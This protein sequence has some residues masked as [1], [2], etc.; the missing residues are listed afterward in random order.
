MKKRLIILVDFSLYSENLIRYACDWSLQ[1][2]AE[3]L[4]VHQTIVV[5]PGLINSEDKQKI[6]QWSNEEALQKLKTLAQTLIPPAVPVSF[7]VSESHLQLTL[8]KLLAEPYENLIFV[9]LKGTGLLKKVFLGSVA[10]DVIDHSNNI[11]VAIPK[12]IEVYAHPKIFVAVQEKHPLN[13]LELNRFLS[14]LGKE[15]TSIT[16]FYLAKPLEETKGVAQQ[17]KDLAVLFSDRFNTNFEIYEGRNAFS[18]IEKVINSK[19]DELLIVQKGARLL[20]D[21]FFRRFLINHLV[22][23]GQT[24]L[25]VL[26]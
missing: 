19:I 5:A 23:K 10:L 1:A 15:R 22:Y 2:Q 3:L 26:P 9:G 20:T 16:F 25:I 13:I 8:S 21:L 6:V 7:L 4:L 24:P 11:V 17:L 14:F 18:A 12:E